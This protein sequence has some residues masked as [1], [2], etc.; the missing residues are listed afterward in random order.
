MTSKKQIQLIST[1]VKRMGIKSLVGKKM[2]REVKF[3]GENVTINKLSVAEVMEIQEKAKKLE[4]DDSAGLEV[5]L[6]IIRNAVEGA[7]ELSESDFE[8]LP[9]DELSKLSGEIMKFSGIQG[10]KPQGK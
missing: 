8:A 1:G 4:T 5:L 9:M 7:E 10:E 6:S 3:M 2:S